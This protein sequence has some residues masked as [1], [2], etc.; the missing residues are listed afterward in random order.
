MKHGDLRSIGHNLADSLASGLGLPIGFVPTSVFADADKSPDGMIT[1]DF[2]AGTIK[3]GRA[4]ADLRAAVAAYRAVLE[5][6]C[7]EKGARM[8]DVRA[9]DAQFWSDHL[10]R[11]AR[12]TVEDGA[13]KRSTDMYRGSPL[14]KVKGRT[15]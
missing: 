6:L 15:R 13:G 11:H 4:S 10:G 8:G 14:K 2:L 7:A 1:I 9:V 5:R 12:V 3:A